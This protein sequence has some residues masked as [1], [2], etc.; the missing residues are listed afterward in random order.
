MT[1]HDVRRDFL[2]AE[3]V[4]A[5]ERC[6]RATLFAL[7]QEEGQVTVPDHCLMHDATL[8]LPVQ[9]LRSRRVLQRSCACG[10]EG[11]TSYDS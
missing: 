3:A 2:A 10:I 6:I 7:L 4:I 1:N 11:G 8:V 5:L 9:S